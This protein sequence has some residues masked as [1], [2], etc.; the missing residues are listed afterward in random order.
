LKFT[1]INDAIK[2]VS[3]GIVF[4]NDEIYYINNGSYKN[5]AEK[6]NTPL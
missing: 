1:N 4:V 2:N 6:L 5:I 3:E